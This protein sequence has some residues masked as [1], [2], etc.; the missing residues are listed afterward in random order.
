LVAVPAAALTGLRDEEVSDLK[1]NEGL[2][3][4]REDA[5]VS[6]MN[7]D[8]MRVRGESMTPKTR[9]DSFPFVD[10]EQ[11]IVVVARIRA[12]GAETGM[13]RRLQR[14][15]RSITATLSRASRLARG[16]AYQVLAWRDLDAALQAIDAIP[17][18]GR[19][20]YKALKD[21]MQ[22]ILAARAKLD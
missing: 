7:P 8:V 20:A 17:Q 14:T 10:V 1:K 21:A 9:Q 22:P 13:D 15:L 12:G 3:P 19:E 6:L 2:R 18:V 11:L 16:N 5:G 4:R